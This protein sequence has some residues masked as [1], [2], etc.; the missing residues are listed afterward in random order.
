MVDARPV[1]NQGR[2][3][4]IRTTY[5]AVGTVTAAASAAPF[6]TI[7]GKAGIV[8]RVRRVRVL[9]ATLT[10]AAILKV[11]ATKY[12]TLATAGTPVAATKVPLDSAGKAS[13]A[14]VQHYTAA[15]TAGTAVGDAGIAA[16]NGLVTG[17]TAN[18]DD[19]AIEFANDNKTE[20]GMIRGATEQIGIRFA[21]APASA[22]TLDYEI[23]WTEDGN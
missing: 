3:A 10:A 9:N 1:D 21:V 7:A 16:L 8:I 19:K 23:E 18:P 4:G 17:A 2:P 11:I 6:L 15:P 14:T 22:P 13:D 5:R 12:S 20:Y